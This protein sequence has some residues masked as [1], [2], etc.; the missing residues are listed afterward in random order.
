MGRI[1]VNKGMK[2]IAKLAK[3]LPHRK[4]KIA[5]QGN[6]S[7]FFEG[8]NNVEYV[9]SLEGKQRSDFLQGAAAMIH[10]TLYVEPFGG[11]VVESQLCG[12]PV[13]L[14]NFGA[15]VETI[16]EG[17]TG[18]RCNS[19]KEY[20]SA[21][22]KVERLDRKYISERAVKLYSL[23]SVGKQFDNVFKQIYDLRDNVDGSRKNI[24]YLF[25]LNKSRIN[26]VVD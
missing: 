16:E 6:F 10:P 25:D 2:I 9:G 12:V 20:L 11:S 21:I 14:T 1:I 15:F 22:E 3:A 19:F 24:S 17:K 23:E 5:G 26:N 7:E 4:F 18:F 13:I 8:I